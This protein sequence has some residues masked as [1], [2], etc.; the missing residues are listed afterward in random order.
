MSRKFLIFIILIVVILGVVYL[1]FFK[2]SKQAPVSTEEKT[3]IDSGGTVTT[4]DCCKLTNDFPNTC[5]IG[6]CGCSPDNSHEVK[7]CDCGDGCWDGTKCVKLNST[8]FCGTSTNGQCSTDSDC[9]TGGCSGQV[10]QSK[11]EEP[12][13]TTCEYTECYNAQIYGVTCG[14]LDNKCQWK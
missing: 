13:I 10:C 5:L 2:E 4:A 7:I 1:V 3:C 11:S 12:V 6:A 9:M 14:C 8:G